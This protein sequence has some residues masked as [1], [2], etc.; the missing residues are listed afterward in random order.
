MVHHPILHTIGKILLL[1]G[2]INWGLIGLFQFNLIGA[3]FGEM[4]AITRIIYVL[5]GLAA[6]YK[7]GCWMKHHK[8]C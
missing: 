2:G 1:I 5:V 4:H 7:I 3:I 8:K 6:L